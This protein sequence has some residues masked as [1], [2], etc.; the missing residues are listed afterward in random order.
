MSGFAALL[1]QTAWLREF[2]FVFGTAE[3]AVVSVL[4]A[5][6]AGLAGGAAVAAR[7][8]DHIRRPVLVY[9]ALELGIAVCALAV[10]QGL[11]LAT[12]LYVF[13]FGG[14][15]SPPDGEQLTGTIFFAVCSFAI[16]ALPTGLMG[17]TLPLLARYAIRK[18][19]E[20]GRRIALLYAVNTGGAVAGTLC[21][22]FLLLPEIGLR[23]TVHVGALVNGLIFLLAV[24]VARTH[25]VGGLPTQ[26][27][28][29]P[30][31][32]A[33]WILPAIAVSGAVSFGFEVL[34]TR[35]LGQILGGSIYAFA[36]MLASFLLG[37]TLGSALASRF[38]DNLRNSTRGFAIAQLGTAAASLAAYGLL[39]W[40]PTLAR[41]IGASSHGTLTANAVVAAAFLLPAALFIG[42]TFPLAVRILA[43]DASDA[44]TATA[45]VYAWNTTGSIAGALSTGLVLLP[46]LGFEGLIRVACAANLLLALTACRFSKPTLRTPA[47]VAA[48]GL[49]CLLAF[50]PDPPWRI[51]RTSP[52][53]RGEAAGEVTHYGVGRSSTVLLL[54]PGTSWRLTTGG[55]NEAEIRPPGSRPGEAATTRWLAML[56]ILARPE[57][58]DVLLIGLGGGLT[59]QAIPSTV[60]HID[61]IELES[62]VVKAN[63]AVA[64]VRDFDPLAD[65]RVHIHVNDAR[66]AL[67]LTTRRYDAIISQPS[68]PWTAGSSHLYTREFFSLIRDHLSPGGVFSQWIGLRFVDEDLLRTIVAT[69]Q[70]TFAN[71]RLYQPVMGSVVFLASDAKLDLEAS[72]LRALEMAAPDFAQYGLATPE[73]LVA[74]LALNEAGAL[75]FARGGQINTDHNNRLAARSPQLLPRDSMTRSRVLKTFAP[76]D[77]PEAHHQGLRTVYLARRLAIASGFQ[78]ANRFIS[79]IADPAERVAA[80]G[81]IEYWS[82]RPVAARR[83]FEGALEQDPNS[84]EALGGLLLLERFRVLSGEASETLEALSVLPVK[85]AAVLAGWRALSRTDMAQLRELDANLASLGSRHP[86]YM[87]SARLRAEWRLRQGG[88]ELAR[89]AL[90]IVNAITVV[91]P[92]ARDLVLRSRAALAAGFALGAVSSLE[93]VAGRI[94]NPRQLRAMGVFAILDSVPPGEADIPVARLRAELLSR[95]E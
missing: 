11:G 77:P 27:V 90:E 28:Q 95:R 69:L 62:E 52:S 29:R 71:V 17:V 15:S 31:L 5:Y 30:R 49:A 58:E 81:W 51:L 20:V 67:V 70:D 8:A 83:H 41:A 59:L 54:N 4:A 82:Q 87:E 60:K 22:A 1:Y 19:E 61:V 44:A 47:A 18:Q 78:R 92:G 21:A 38:A 40:A 42:A 36:T 93:D 80:Q 84:I 57:S 65:P 86:L 85:E 14:L 39:G 24:L 94:Q 33:G 72:A 32:R 26:T 76:Y 50:P 48:I 56:P 53:T 23:S 3:L 13:L 91:Q 64:N 43:R 45:R 79:S 34:W 6:M 75:E 10:P 68:H 25:T 74:G 63:R 12:R 55:L 66:G 37:I 16:L 46:G 9:G 88:S 73:D 2:A 7:V 35:L 89:E